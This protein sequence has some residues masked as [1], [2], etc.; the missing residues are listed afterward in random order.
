MNETAQCKCDTIHVSLNSHI[1]HRKICAPMWRTILKN[2][3]KVTIFF[4]QHV[5]LVDQ[6]PFI[7]VLAFLLDYD[8]YACVSVCTMKLN[9]TTGKKSTK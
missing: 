4:P 5:Q 6:M 8:E 9:D 3:P 2:E 7:N 1:F